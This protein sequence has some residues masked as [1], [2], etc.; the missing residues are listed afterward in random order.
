MLDLEK[1][2][3]AKAAEVDSANKK[4]PD[5]CIEHAALGAPKEDKLMCLRGRKYNPERASELL[6]QMIQLKRDYDLDNTA[7]D[8]DTERL[9]LDL[10][11]HT[12]C[13]AGNYRLAVAVP[14]VPVV[15]ALLSSGIM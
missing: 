5:D 2:L 4:P 13:F 9:K 6:L 7:Q 1:L 3:V 15:D 11:S 14:A 10:S 12:V 8:A